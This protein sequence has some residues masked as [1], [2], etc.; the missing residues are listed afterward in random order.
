MPHKKIREKV[1]RD[2]NAIAKEFSQTRSASWEEFESFLPYYKSNF[3]VLDLGCGNGRLIDFLKKHGY[4]SYLGV[5]FSENLIAE[6]RRLH[7][8]E[9]FLVADMIDPSLGRA[10]FDAIFVIASFHH[11]PPSEQVAALRAWK[12]LLKP[13][14]YLFMTNWNLFQFK[15]W[16]SWLRAILWPRYGFFGLQIPWQNKVK[17]YYYAFTKRRLCQHLLTTGFSVILC[18]KNRNIVIVART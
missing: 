17:R 3:F 5:D 14:G 11:L 12:K 8:K 7:P 9:K 4:A 6:A 2:Y 16:R 15:F 1:K 18:E 10:K 13:G